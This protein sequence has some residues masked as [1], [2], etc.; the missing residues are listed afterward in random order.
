MSPEL[1]QVKSLVLGDLERGS[2]HEPLCYVEWG[3]RYIADGGHAIIT[4]EKTHPISVWDDLASR[5]DA[6]L[7]DRLTGPYIHRMKLWEPGLIIIQK[8]MRA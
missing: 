1:V 3:L 7:F 6:Y 4:S 5:L 2:P 8:I